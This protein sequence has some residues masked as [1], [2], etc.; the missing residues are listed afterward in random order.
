[1]LQK[2]DSTN[3]TAFD[4]KIAGIVDIHYKLVLTKFKGKI[5]PIEQDI[6]GRA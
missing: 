2:R 3:T 5:G 6:D 1:M 4:V